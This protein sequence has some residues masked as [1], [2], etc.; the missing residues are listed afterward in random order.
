MSRTYFPT[1]NDNGVR[2]LSQ[3]VTLGG[4]LYTDYRGPAEPA[5]KAAMNPVTLGIVTNDC[6]ARPLYADYR[7]DRSGYSID[8]R[9]WN[10]CNRAPAPAA[11]PVSSQSTPTPQVRVN[12]VP[13]SNAVLVT[14]GGGTA[15]PAPVSSQAGITPSP[16]TSTVNVTAAPPAASVTDQVAAWLGGTTPI[17]SY[18]VP[19]ALIAGGVAIVVAMMMSGG[20]GRKR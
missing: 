17:F 16:T 2:D 7:D 9:D 1:R 20:T 13:Q 18:S 15:S 14:S 11:P 5:P 8:L 4:Y 3:S 10:A 6:G 12:A 19:N